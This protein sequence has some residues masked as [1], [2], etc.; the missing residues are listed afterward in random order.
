[1]VQVAIKRF[2][3]PWDNQLSAGKPW[4]LFRWWANLDTGTFNRLDFNIKKQKNEETGRVEDIVV[5]DQ[6]NR[7]KGFVV[8]LDKS[9]LERIYTI[10]ATR[11]IGLFDALVIHKG[12]SFFPPNFLDAVEN[13]PC[14]KAHEKYAVE[15]E[16][17]EPAPVVKKKAAKKK[18]RKKRAAKTSEM[19]DILNERLGDPEE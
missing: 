11:D 14:Y 6:V 7:L 1:M 19:E 3:L 2:R 10:S 17:P 4:R 12:E 16:K 13:V 15:E 8:E 5:G 18:A 9:D